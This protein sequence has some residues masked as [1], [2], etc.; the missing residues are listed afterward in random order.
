MIKR[1][2]IFA[3]LS[4]L[5]CLVLVSCGNPLQKKTGSKSSSGSKEQP[6]EL[7]RLILDADKV[8]EKLT[9]IEETER[10]KASEEK[11]KQ[12]GQ[13]GDQ[14]QQEMKTEWKDIESSLEKLHEGFNAFEPKAEEENISK[15]EITGFEDELNKLSIAV[16]DKKIKEA[17]AAANG[18]QKHFP[19]FFKHYKEDVPHE[20][21]VVKYNY[22]EIYVKAV[23]KKWKDASEADKEAL[24]AWDEISTDIEKEDK[25][26]AKKTEMSLKDL[27]QALKTEDITVVAAKI[28]VIKNNYKAIEKLFKD[29]AEEQQKDKGKK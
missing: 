12:Q 26:L 17:L 16:K 10:A 18:I 28:K 27:E 5:L 7:I 15:E 2:T 3:I 13:G 4:I 6:A 8:F 11:G 23:D 24:K 22:Q 25:E 1:R 21:Y 19:E 29:K 20:L 14:G 9:K